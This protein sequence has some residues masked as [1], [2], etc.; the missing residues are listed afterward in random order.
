MFA[1]DGC[2]ISSNCSKEWSGTRKD[3]EKKRRKLEKLVQRLVEKHRRRDELEL[4]DEAVKK[5]RVAIRRLREKVK[6]IRAWLKD[7]D[8]KRG[9]SG[10]IKQSNLTDNES[11]KMP[12]G[13]GVIQ[14]H[15]GIALVDSKHQVVMHAETH[16]EGQE[17]RLLIAFLDSARESVK[18][19]GISDNIF[20]GAKLVADAGNHSEDNI[21]ELE[22][23]HI[24][25]YVADNKFR[26]RDPQFAT[27]NRHKRSIDRK[28]T[29]LV[30]KNKYFTARDF[31]P[32]EKTGKL[33]CPA[34]NELYVKNR[35]QYYRKTG[36]RGTLYNG[37]KTKCRGCKLRAKCIRGK[38]T[39]HRTVLITEQGVSAEHSY[40]KRMIEKFDTPMGRFY[41]SRRLGI[42]EPVFGHQRH[43]MGLDR[44]TLRGTNTDIQWKLYTMV[45]NMKKLWRYAPRFAY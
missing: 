20:E 3:F 10:N 23:R 42:V 44:F 41:Y 30:R 40:T 39:E 22:Q 5:E 6:K 43:A 28:H 11:A 45:H 9:P 14:G 12:T 1:V 27:Q 8:D 36:V 33:I 4:D 38:R 37:W 34:G 26:K 21:K 13:H 19:A 7:N 2:K 16:G 32:D 31:R 35:N 17:Q 15:N 29:P 24:D 25:A 18:Q